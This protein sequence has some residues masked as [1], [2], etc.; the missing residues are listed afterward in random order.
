VRTALVGA[1]AGVLLAAAPLSASAAPLSAES[2]ESA[3]GVLEGSVDIT[4]QRTKL[5]IFSPSMGKTIAVEVLHPVGDAPRPSFYLLDGVTAGAESGYVESTWTQRTDVEGYFADKNVNVVLPIGGLGAYY[6]DWQQEDPVLGVNK[7]E[8]FLTSELPPIIDSVMY[9]N[10]R[11]AVAGLSMGGLAAANLATRYPDLYQ[12]LS[13][14]S[15]CV[16]TTDENWYPTVRG[17]VQSRGGNAD[18]MWG[19]FGSEDWVAHNPW[20]N[21]EQLRGTQVILYA[22]GPLDGPIP[23]CTVMFRD[24]LTAMGIPS[25]LILRPEGMH[26]WGSWEVAVHDSWPEIAQALQTS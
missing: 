16:D 11:N 18:N 12:S 2:A 1:L 22:G 6:T 4:P 24:R 26:K 17:V 7:W 20:L 9:G 8:T 15:S 13:V 14:Y 3:P 25:S 23:V 19:P 21:A 5:L 10:G